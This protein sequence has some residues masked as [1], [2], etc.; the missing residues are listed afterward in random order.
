M[1]RHAL[2]L[3]S[4]TALL[5][6]AACGPKAETQNVESANV[7]A[8]DVP[9]APAPILSPG[10]TFANTAASSDA[11]EIAT[12]KLALETSKS[13]SIK[14]F[15]GKMVTAHEESTAKLKTAASAAS[16]AILPDPMLTAEQDAKLAALRAKTGADFDTAYAAEQGAAHQA[17]LDALRGYSANGDVASLKTFA[18]QMVPIVAAHLNMA[19][20][21]KP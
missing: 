4:G 14:A 20:S 11:F 9:A 12:S 17:A 18:G 19:K 5:A 8:A 13:A 6:L 3:L 16:P 1:K 15:A 10:Q 7:A 2:T 21:L